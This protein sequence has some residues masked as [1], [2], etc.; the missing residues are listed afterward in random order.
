MPRVRGARYGERVEKLK[1]QGET[2]YVIPLDAF[3]DVAGGRHVPWPGNY[4]GVCVGKA[5][6][7]GP[8]RVQ[9]YFCDFSIDA[10]VDTGSEYDAFEFHLSRLQEQGGNSSFL[11]RRAIPE[12]FVGGLT[13]GMR[14]STASTSDLR[15]ILN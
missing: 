3:H 5:S 1:S 9:V 14:Q 2:V 6:R 7:P 4:A 11:S 15:L 12:Q 13:E 10:L 8:C